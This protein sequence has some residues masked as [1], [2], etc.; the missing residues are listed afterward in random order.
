MSV[1]YIGITTGSF[2]KS[3]YLVL[4]FIGVYISYLIVKEKLSLDGSLSKFCKISENTDCQS[5]LKSKEAK[6]F[7]VVDLSDA[8]IIYFSFISI[9]FIF[10]HNIVLFKTLSFLSLSVIIYSIYYQYFIIKKWC[11]LCLMVAGVLFLQFVVLIVVSNEEIFNLLMLLIVLLI[12]ATIIIFWIKIKKLLKESFESRKLRIENLTFRRNYHLFFSYYNSLPQ[13]DTNEDNILDISFGNPNAV[14]KILVITNPL[15][16]L[17]FETHDLMMKLLNKHENKIF[18]KF[19]FFVPFENRNDPKTQIAE[20]LIDLF[21]NK[22]NNT[23]LKAFNHWY[24]RVSINEWLIKWGVTKDEKINDLVKTQVIW[25]AKNNI[26]QTPTVL[27]NKKKFP[28]FYNPKGKDITL[29]VYN[30]SRVINLNSNL[31]C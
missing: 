9:A 29:S 21:L 3:I 15:C 25:C 31:L 18:V 28:N 11:P 17:C 12:L 22:S 16:E 5:V 23:F 6:V 26:N 1:F 14:V 24:S 7:N 13:I 27:I 20:R 4:S 2:L 10:N 19:R 30:G 8:S